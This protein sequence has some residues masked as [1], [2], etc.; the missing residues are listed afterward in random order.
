MNHKLVVTEILSSNS[1]AESGTFLAYGY[2]AL[3]ISDVTKNLK[4][5]ATALE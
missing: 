1:Q 2:T 5:S 3:V 4:V